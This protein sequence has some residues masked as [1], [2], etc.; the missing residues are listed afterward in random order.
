MAEPFLGEIRLASFGVLPRGWAP[1]NGQLLPIA[2][3]AALFSLLGTTYGGDGRTTFALPNL[4]GRVP[5]HVGSGVQ[6]GQAGGEAAHALTVAEMPAHNHAALASTDLANSASP[7]GNVPGAKGRG[8]RDIYA[9]A[10]S[11]PVALNA[12]SIPANGGGAAHPNLQPY[13]PLNFM[14]ALQGIF[15]S[16]P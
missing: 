16:R 8:G 12:G 13:L 10:G 1:C 4:Q 6:L 7:A 14:I 9:A 3:N 2:Q 5:M 15:P 11:A